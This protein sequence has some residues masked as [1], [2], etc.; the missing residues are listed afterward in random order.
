MISVV[1]FIPS[2]FESFPQA[3]WKVV[4]HNRLNV[5]RERSG[6]SWLV[7][8]NL[9]VYYKWSET[10]SISCTNSIFP[11]NF[12]R[13]CAQYQ[14]KTTSTVD[15]LRLRKDLNTNFMI[16]LEICQKQPFDIIAMTPRGTL[17]LSFVHIDQLM[18]D[19]A[20]YRLPCSYVTNLLA[21]CRG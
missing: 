9:L 16:K 1:N 15:G 21:Y 3:F 12:I 13:V 19:P 18:T 11:L 4:L 2:K 10:R 17:G 14:F 6:D 5:Y 8:D 7:T 20:V